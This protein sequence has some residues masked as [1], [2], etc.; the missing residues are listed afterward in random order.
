MNSIKLQHKNGYHI[1]GLWKLQ[2]IDSHRLSLNLSHKIDL[3]RSDKYAT[4]SNLRVYY[5]WKNVRNSCKNNKFE[6]SATNV[7]ITL[8]YY[9]ISL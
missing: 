9:F 8:H 5:T 2:N 3:K 7:L 4:L 6:I 1:H